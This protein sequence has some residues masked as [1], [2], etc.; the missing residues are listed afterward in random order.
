MT[1]ATAIPRIEGVRLTAVDVPYRPELGTL[2]TAGMTQ[3]GARHVLVEVFAD[4]GS[5]GLGEAVPRPSVYGETL[6]GIRAACEQLL[7]PPLLGM[8]ATDTERAWAAWAS[9]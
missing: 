2:V 9:R 5:V 1:G 8:A 6:D 3:R 4:D 7:A